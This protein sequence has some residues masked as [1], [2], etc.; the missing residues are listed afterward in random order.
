[1][2]ELDGQTDLINTLAF[3]RDNSTLISAGIDGTIRFWNLEHKTVERTI[4][5]S[6]RTIRAV[7]SSDRHYLAVTSYDVD[8]AVVTDRSETLIYDVNTGEEVRK[9][10]IRYD[11]YEFIWSHAFSPDNRFLAVGT[12]GGSRIRL[13]DLEQGQEA[14]VLAINNDSND[15]IKD[16]VFS[17]SGKYV[18]A[19]V[20]GDAP[21]LLDANTG[22]QLKRYGGA[23]CEAK[24]RGLTP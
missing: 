19:G 5:T 23:P 3:G 7:V 21:H 17:H 24:Q 22:L 12:I 18:L 4:K 14:W 9:F 15:G 10:T 16:L 11:R 2:F 1:V 8:Q 20:W 13:F 6:K